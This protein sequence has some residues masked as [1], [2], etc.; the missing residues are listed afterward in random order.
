MPTAATVQ[1]TAGGTQ[2]GTGARGANGRTNVVPIVPFIR[3]S[4]EH[5]EPCGIDV[6]RQLL[7]SG[8]QDLG[9]FDVP[10]YGYVRNLV[11]VVQR[12]FP[13]LCTTGRGSHRT[14]RRCHCAVQFRVRPG[15]GEQVGRLRE[16]H[17]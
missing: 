1:P 5:T 10:A 2:Q 4:M 13:V 12:G 9:V 17:W 7:T 6:Q 16:R 3:A 15:H 8:A 11:L 14:E